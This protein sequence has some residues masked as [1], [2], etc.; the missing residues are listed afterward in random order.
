[1]RWDIFCQIIDN[2]G[3]AGICWRLARSLATQYDQNIR[4][5]C[6]DLHTLQLIMM[7]QSHLKSI[8]VL[9]WEASYQNARH[10]P[11]VPDV[12]IQAFSCELPTRYLN[13]I[14]VAPQKPILIHLEYLS[15]EPWVADFHGKPSP[16]TH[17]LQKY[18]FFPGFQPN[19]GGLLLD[20]IPKKDQESCPNSLKDI[21]QQSRPDSKKMSIFS[22]PGAPIKEWLA[23]LNRLQE[24]FDIF[25]AFGNAELLH[26]QHHQWPNLNLIS[27]PFIPQDDYDWLL[28]HCD[29]NIVRGE[30]SFIRAQLAGK[31]FIWNIYPQDDGAHHAKLKAF[32]DLYLEGIDP[33]LHHSITA[34]MNWRDAQDWW[35]QLAKWAVHAQHWQR[36]L[37]HQQSDGGLAGRLVQFVS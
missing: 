9:P 32:L 4:L 29:F 6:D 27:M 28:A 11:E 31:P 23:N 24:P 18:F 21:S 22:Y 35:G 25:L 13:G 17:G 5:F 14:L 7:E 19:T 36:A 3:D 10:Q 8:E 34:A 2:Y 26:L 1:M 30:D 33:Q 15:A 16:N 12:V 37:I 20:P